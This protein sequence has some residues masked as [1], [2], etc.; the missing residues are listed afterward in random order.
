MC[1]IAGIFHFD[2]SRTVD[3]TLLQRMTDAVAHRGPDGEGFFIKE[4][5]GLGHRRLSIIDLE[6]GHQPMFNKDR[7]V[8]V[9]FNGE[10]YNYLELREDL[11]TLG[12]SFITHSDTEVIIHA[13]EQWGIECQNKLNGMWGFAL[14][15]G[16]KKQIFISR[17]RI[18]EKPIH[19][20]VVDNTFLF[21]SE[22]KSILCYPHE[23]LPEYRLLDIYLTM[24]YIPAPYTFYKNI[25]KLRPGH[26][27]IICENKLREGVYW[28]LPDISER[29]MRSDESAVCKEF[30]ALFEDSVK[31]RMRSDVPIGAFLSGGMDSSAVVSVMSGFSK[32]PVS[33]FTIGFR[34]KAFDERGLANIVANT[35]HTIHHEQIVEPSGFEESL[36]KIL[37]HYDEPFADSS[38]IPTGYVSKFAG[39]IVKLVLTGDGGDEVLSGYTS[40]QGEKWANQFQKVPASVRIGLRHVLDAASYLFSGDLRYKANRLS[41]LLGSANLS[42]EDR[43]IS[44]LTYV[45][46]PTI[47]ALTR[48]YSDQIRTEDFI[49]DLVKESSFTDPFYK[50]MYFHLKVNLPDDMLTKVDR[51]SMAYSIETRTPFLDYRI[52]ELLYGV[53]KQV[54]LP[55]YNRKNILKKTIGNNLPKIILNSPKRGFSVPLR[56]WFRE[57]SFDARLNDL[58][59]TEW[60]LDNNTIGKIIWMHK[61]GKQDYSDFIWRLEVLRHWI[62]ET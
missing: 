43:L 60:H 16:R 47:R 40:Y 37:M 28:S 62:Q 7:T 30:M 53:D 4:N 31:I 61:Q 44:K 14:W 29:D 46:R 54:K 56:K 35:F 13:Y 38:A 1:G 36:Q 18:G 24:S 33:T 48:N 55:G 5:I 19:Y 52:V 22:L 8:A 6:T 10:I 34:D 58:A 26:Y 23:F 12:H 27:L 42:F 9:I 21:G 20:A 11:K 59:R 15:D 51:M 39:E 3:E 57:D 41:R 2:P 45:S 25:F 50:L 32:I 49:G 17:D